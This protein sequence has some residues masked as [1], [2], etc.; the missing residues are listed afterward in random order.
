M[1]HTI[2]LM[3][4]AKSI[5]LCLIRNIKQLWSGHKSAPIFILYAN[6]EPPT[7]NLLCESLVEVCVFLLEGSAV[8]SVG[9][10]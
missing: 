10:N 5:T 7:A 2:E 8:E 4:V 9:E 3:V 6:G 1:V